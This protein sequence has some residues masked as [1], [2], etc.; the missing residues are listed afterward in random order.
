MKINKKIK[1]IFKKKKDNI[2]CDDIEDLIGLFQKDLKLTKIKAFSIIWFIQ[3]VIHQIPDKFEMCNTCES[4]FDTESS[5]GS[6]DDGNYC[7]G[8]D[9]HINSTNE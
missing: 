5:G 6:D 3:E 1:N 9:T 2:T 4:I 7:D 8:C